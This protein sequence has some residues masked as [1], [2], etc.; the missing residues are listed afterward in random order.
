MPTN[1]PIPDLKAMMQG[2]GPVL[3]AFQ[4]AASF[5]T[6]WKPSTGGQVSNHL[7]RKMHEEVHPHSLAQQYRDLEKM[8]RGS[9]HFEVA[10]TCQELAYCAEN[11]LPYSQVHRVLRRL[12]KDHWFGIAI[13]S[14]GGDSTTMG[15]SKLKP[16]FVDERGLPEPM[17]YWEEL[18]YGD[19]G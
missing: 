7:W 2:L 18:A 16:P 9:G 3:N 10:C 13:C 11:E 15:Y 14:V 17:S 12:V 5:M 6:N 19:E 4:A 8:A 1:T